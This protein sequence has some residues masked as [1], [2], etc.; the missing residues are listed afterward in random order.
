LNGCSSKG[1]PIAYV[2]G[3]RVLVVR[4]DPPDVP[5]GGLSMVSALAI[6]TANRPIAMT[7]TQCLNPPLQ[8]DQVNPD[9]ITNDAAEYLV[10]IGSG[11]SI[12]T[13]MP[14]V[15]PSALGLP[16]ASGG[17]YVPLIAHVRAGMDT[18]IA[19]YLLRLNVG[20]PPNQNPTLS[21]VF[22]VLDK[23]D[24]G[25]GGATVPIDDAHPRAV[26][27]GDKISLRATFAPGSAEG[28][29]LSD[30]PVTETL[31]VWWYSTAGELTDDNATGG[32]V[33]DWTLDLTS[34]HLPASGSTIDLWV[35]GQDERGGADYLHRTLNFE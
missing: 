26:H 35:I 14:M 16:D 24:G 15:G 17:V 23:A 34:F 33:R 25:A 8:G 9:C 1:D 3:L 13:T 6:D 4:A 19:S 7:W 27:A 11:L 22:E 32:D 29:L 20:A 5:A 2:N 12:T 31:T 28:Y 10:P 21:G 18:M 30:R